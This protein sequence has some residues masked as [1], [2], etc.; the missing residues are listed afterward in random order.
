MVTEAQRHGNGQRRTT[1]EASVDN[2]GLRTKNVA[3][4]MENGVEEFSSAIAPQEG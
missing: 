1:T 3:H 2:W 4:F